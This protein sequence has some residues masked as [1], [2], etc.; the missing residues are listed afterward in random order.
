MIVRLFCAALILTC[1]SCATSDLRVQREETYLNYT[2]EREGENLATVARRFTGSAANWK[3]LIPYNPG[4][5]AYRLRPGEVVRIPAH[6]MLG[7]QVPRT[8]GAPREQAGPGNAAPPAAEQS[9][10]AKPQPTPTP[11]PAAEQRN[12]P[13][14]APAPALGEP[15]AGAADQERRKV[16][17][18]RLLDEILQE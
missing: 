10:P 5:D 12:Q 18:D 6:L 17:R 9:A 11:A 8:H 2:V 4:V 15:G 3:A 13:G 7:E 1:G 16:L 14:Q